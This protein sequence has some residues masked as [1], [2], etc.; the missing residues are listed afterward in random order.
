MKAFIAIKLVILSL[1]ILPGY[2]SLDT[3]LRS[4]GWKKSKSSLY[5]GLTTS[6][7]CLYGCLNTYKNAYKWDR[8]KK[9][10]EKLQK[11]NKLEQELLESIN[12][13][14]EDGNG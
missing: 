1:V 4:C 9:Q 6:K 11:Q 13:V 8:Y 14:P 3:C 10:Q 12:T 5:Y 2:F 7:K